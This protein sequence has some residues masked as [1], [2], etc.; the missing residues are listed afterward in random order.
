MPLESADPSELAMANA[1]VLAALLELLVTREVLTRI[2][3]RSILAD[4]VQTLERD[5]EGA[6]VRGAVDVISKT[7]VPRFS[8]RPDA[9]QGS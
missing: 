4:A 6:P 3:V 8:E 2:D 1:A 9:G 5:A 7:L